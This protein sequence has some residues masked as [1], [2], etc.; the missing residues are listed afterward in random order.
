[1][2]EVCIVVDPLVFPMAR[3]LFAPAH[4]MPIFGACMGHRFD[5][6]VVIGN[7]DNAPTETSKAAWRQWLD[8]YLPTKLAPGGVL[9]R[10][11]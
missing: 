1:M 6:I 3:K 10:A 11:T 9:E 5:L 4:V 7:A 8:E 2:A